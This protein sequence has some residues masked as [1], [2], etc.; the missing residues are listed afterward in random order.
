M[1]VKKINGEQGM[2]NQIWYGFSANSYMDCHQWLALTNF[3]LTNP[4]IFSDEDKRI[5]GMNILAQK[6]CLKFDSVN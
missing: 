5:T 4:E 6:E 1:K 2:D 3:M